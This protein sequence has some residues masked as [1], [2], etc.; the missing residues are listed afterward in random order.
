MREILKRLTG[1]DTQK[2]HKLFT[3]LMS[4]TTVALNV[5]QQTTSN[6]V[7]SGETDL[8]ALAKKY[9]RIKNLVHKSIGEVMRLKSVGAQLSE[10]QYRQESQN[11]EL[12][13]TQLAYQKQLSSVSTTEQIMPGLA[14]IAAVQK[15]LKTA[16][17]SG[18][19]EA[20]RDAETTAR[21]VTANVI[22]INRNAIFSTVELAKKALEGL[23]KYK[24]TLINPEA[25]HGYKEA[26]DALISAKQKAYALDV[27]A[28]HVAMERVKIGQKASPDTLKK[29]AQAVSKVLQQRDSI[30][31]EFANYVIQLGNLKQ[32]TM[33][34]YTLQGNLEKSSLANR[35]KNIRAQME[36]I[37]KLKKA[38]GGNILEQI[39]LTNV[40]KDK[41]I[42]AYSA[43]QKSREGT[44]EVF[45]RGPAQRAK[46]TAYDKYLPEILA[47]IKRT[48]K[49]PVDTK[50]LAIM[51]EMSA[52]AKESIRI[53]TS[54]KGGNIK[55]SL[56]KLATSIV[57]NSDSFSEM[58]NK[59]IH[60]KGYHQIARD[61]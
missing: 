41:M 37:R 7:K 11:I 57:A 2:A 25:L 1:G 43:I 49:L 54:I 19:K 32:T 27:K 30:K 42:A 44:S 53:A 22:S 29:A 28:F 26:E 20:I 40:L 45:L 5:L 3:K 46:E 16:L 15:R 48:G 10:A 12:L 50:S 51:Q 60:Q 18:N 24:L 56:K 13:K 17:L 6:Y 52:E 31:N 35:L 39:K 33:D 38:A 8:T 34:L 55:E 58:M 23:T 59:V 61:D 4:N 36:G 9:E 47:A 21:A 14:N